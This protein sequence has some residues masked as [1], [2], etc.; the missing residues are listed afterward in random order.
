V[1]ALRREQTYVGIFG[2][3]V[4]E[5][6]EGGGSDKEAQCAAVAEEEEEELIIGPSLHQRKGQ[7]ASGRAEKRE[8]SPHILRRARGSGCLGERRLAKLSLEEPK[9]LTDPS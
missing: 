2:D 5:L 7:L 4:D 6:R 1:L 8:S 9:V 3:K